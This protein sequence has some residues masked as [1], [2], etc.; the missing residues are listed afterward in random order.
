M[1]VELLRPGGMPGGKG[2]LRPWAK[3]RLRA[4][5][6]GG[7]LA[8]QEAAETPLLRADFHSARPSYYQQKIKE[9]LKAKPK[10]RPYRFR[11]GLIPRGRGVGFR[12]R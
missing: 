12:A 2:R 4:V 5:G 10:G 11:G 7:G 8:P 9:N 3:A 1:P 6:A